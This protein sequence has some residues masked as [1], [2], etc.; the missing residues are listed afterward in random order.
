MSSMTL[1]PRP[2]ARPG[3][4]LHYHTAITGGLSSG[5]RGYTS[6]R[7]HVAWDPFKLDRWGLQSTS[8]GLAYRKASG[9][10]A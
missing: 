6:G 5:K 4:P 3:Y 2:H 8:P 10:Y 1:L 7:S 9:V